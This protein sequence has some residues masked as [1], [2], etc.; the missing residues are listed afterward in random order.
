[1]DVVIFWGAGQRSE[2]LVAITNAAGDAGLDYR[3]VEIRDDDFLSNSVKEDLYR[4]GELGPHTQVI[5]RF[6]AAEGAAAHTHYLSLSEDGRQTLPAALF[7]SWLRTPPGE[8]DFPLQAPWRGTVH[9]FW[10]RSGRLRDDYQLQRL[11]WRSGPTISYAWRKGGS[12]HN[13]VAAMLDLCAY[14][15]TV[16][17]EAPYLEPEYI[18]ARM[19]GVA[20]DTVACLGGKFKR[21]LVVGAPR[22]SL[23]AQHNYLIDGLQGCNGRAPRMLG[24]SE[25]LQALA[26]AM[27][28]PLVRG[29]ES[30]RQKSKLENVFMVRAE[31]CNLAAMDEL[32]TAHPALLGMTEHSGGSGLQVYR[33]VACSL[34]ISREFNLL[35][36]RQGDAR[37]MLCLLENIAML[38]RQGIRFTLNLAHLI[39]G[40]A[41]LQAASLQWAT[42]QDDA[43]L[44][45]YLL[46]AVN[47]P[48]R[49]GLM[50]QCYTLALQASRS[51]AMELLAQVYPKAT[52]AQLIAVG[53]GHG[54]AEEVVCAW[55]SEI[56]WITSHDSAEVVLAALARHKLFSILAS[57]AK[58]FPGPFKN[59]M[60]VMYENQQL[61]ASYA[62]ALLEYAQETRDRM[63][64][65]QLEQGYFQVD[66]CDAMRHKP[67][68]DAG[69]N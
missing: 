59:L 1:M 61:Y 8:P 64:H 4:S 30:K 63:L 5:A 45:F 21:A 53:I 2:D 33:R 44:F 36:A 66:R 11:A 6:A 52:V 37:N 49:P 69:Q 60:T 46:Q 58:D 34:T 12:D 26:S 16:K 55:L 67:I 18:A 41:E 62:E 24:A 57:Q 9:A 40:R 31:R 43:E 54:A 51:L 42:G 15:G 28:H 65:R 27:R 20:G 38:R 3:I 48:D 39:H 22:T 50:E 32:R 68:N 19:L 35:S 17:G 23:Q 25:D 13:A 56:D 10:A 14:V 7:L 47:P 29:V